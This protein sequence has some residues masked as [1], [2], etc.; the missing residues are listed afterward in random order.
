MRTLFLCP[1]IC[2]FQKFFVILQRKINPLAPT[3]YKSEYKRK[4][5]RNN[6]LK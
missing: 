2:V 5:L 1:F 4:A 3:A 6:I